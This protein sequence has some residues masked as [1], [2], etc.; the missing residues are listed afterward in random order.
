LVS[1]FINSPAVRSAVRC[2]LSTVY[3][4]L[5]TVYCITHTHTHT[6]NALLL[7][8]SILVPH[9]VVLYRLILKASNVYFN[10]HL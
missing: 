8:K 9:T 10:E 2:L 1:T 6:P 5:S 4:L 7:Q 3:C